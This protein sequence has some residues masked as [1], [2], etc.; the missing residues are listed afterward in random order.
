MLS[1]CMPRAEKRAKAREA[2][3]EKRESK[4]SPKSIR[5]GIAPT[6]G[7]EDGK[8]TSGTGRSAY[9]MGGIQET[10][11]KERRR[12]PVKPLKWREGTN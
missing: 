12:M 6:G 10:V 2:A 5:N 1:C 9:R 3:K 7:M 4:K 8:T 11:D